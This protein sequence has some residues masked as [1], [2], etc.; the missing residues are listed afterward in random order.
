MSSGSRERVVPDALLART[1]ELKRYFDLS[2]AYVGTLT[3]KPTTR[4]KE[5]APPKKKPR[6]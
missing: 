3:P 5:A 1:Q 4:K 6:D 2:Y